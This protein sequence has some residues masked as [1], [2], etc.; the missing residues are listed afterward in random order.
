M[1]QILNFMGWYLFWQYWS[2]IT[3]LP[4]LAGPGRL[5]TVSLFKK[6]SKFDNLVK[7]SWVFL[8]AVTALTVHVIMND[9]NLWEVEYFWLRPQ[10]PFSVLYI[11]SP[12][13]YYIEGQDCILKDA[14]WSPVGKW[15][16]TCE[17]K[18]IQHPQATLC[19]VG[20]PTKYH[21]CSL[22]IFCINHLQSTAVNL[23]KDLHNLSSINYLSCCMVCKWTWLSYGY[24]FSWWIHQ[25]TNTAMT[26]TGIGKAKWWNGTFYVNF[27]KFL[28]FYKL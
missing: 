24:N 16:S 11:N 1:F 26:I 19:H 12:T 9:L 4:C 8:Y 20:C 18:H 21:V 6:G 14:T 13:V 2:S 15:Q 22:S 25:K 17:T 7:I 10:L 5:C 27:N 3:I 23:L 28:N